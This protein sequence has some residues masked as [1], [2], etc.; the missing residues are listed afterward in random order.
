MVSALTELVMVWKFAYYEV[1]TIS[2]I[3][4]AP[5]KNLFRNARPRAPSDARPLES[6]QI[7]AL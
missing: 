6:L 3:K 5:H 7:H 1:D 4:V 2:E